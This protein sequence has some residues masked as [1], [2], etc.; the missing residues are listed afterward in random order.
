VDGSPYAGDAYFGGYWRT[1]LLGTTGAGGRAVFALDVTHPDS[2]NA[3]E[4]LWE[5]TDPDLGYTIGQP[6]IGRM[7][8][9]KWA[10]I[11]GNG[12]NSAS[13]RAFL[14]VVDLETGALLRKIDTGAGSAGSPNGL[15]TPALLADNNRIIDYA[16]AGDLLGN[17]WKF[18][19][20]DPTP[21]N[22]KV[23]YDDGATPP[24]PAPLFQAHY[25]VAGT[26]PVDVIQPITAPLE[27]ALHP[28]GG[29][30]IIFGTG[31]YF[32]VG[33]NGSTA[34]QS[35]YGVWDNGARIAQTDRSTLVQQT[36]VAEPSAG[37]STW[38]V[39]SNNP[40]NW[41]GNLGWYVDLISPVS[42]IQG[43]RAVSM[44]ILRGGRAIFT[45]LVPSSDPC[46]SGGTSWI[47]EVDM[48]TGGRLDYSVFNVDKDTDTQ[49]SNADMVT[50]TGIGPVPVSGIQ[51]DVGII[52]TPGIVS[53][54]K[55]EYK[56]AG[57]SSGGIMV[58]PE[59]G[60]AGGG[61]Q[62]WRQLR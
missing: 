40:I 38:R 43:E 13:Q 33:D 44:P 35:L 25:H 57:G 51:S 9:G 12:Y 20:T 31:K 59:K 34:V 17:L 5:F 3:S 28:N 24:N 2:F 42:G 46:A 58:T 30:L 61:R 8:N 6:V 22:W 11:F 4:V 18:D 52:K 49:F 47:M 53:A 21:G 23:A 29:Y 1:V 36:I 50:V 62:S 55:V 54:G 60:D 10:A 41:S 45:T 27:I 19:L 39:V 56:Y 15:A 48:V 32:E 26:P 14:Y 16:Y 7:K 37:G